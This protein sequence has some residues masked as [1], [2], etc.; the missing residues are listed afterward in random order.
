MKHKS[1]I[2][3]YKFSV[4]VGAEC[5]EG[6]YAKTFYIKIKDVDNFEYYKNL[7]IN[8]D[9]KSIYPMTSTPNLSQ[10]QVY[11]YVDENKKVD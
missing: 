10:W 1:F 4:T 8:A 3:F 6:D 2:T 7:I 9:W 5:K 11:K